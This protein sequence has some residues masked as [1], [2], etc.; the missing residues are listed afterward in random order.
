MDGLG[1]V[2]VDSNGGREGGSEIQ[3]KKPSVSERVDD[4]EIKRE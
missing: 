4:E 3:R 1:W 2:K